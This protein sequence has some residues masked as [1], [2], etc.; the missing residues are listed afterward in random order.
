VYGGPIG[1]VLMPHLGG[2]KKYEHLSFASSLCGACT[3]TCPVKIDLH[4]HLLQN[5]RN[6]VREGDRPA[7]ERVAF[8]LW[9]WVM[10]SAGRFVFLGAAGRALLRAA[11]SLGLART[12]FDPLRPWTKTH[13]APRIP[14]KSF[15]VMW[16]EEHGGV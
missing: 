1:S 8:R 12:A 2:L 6:A 15:R 5:R 11:Y 7:G 13:E 4:H 3:N 9:R 14:E 10:M 16:N